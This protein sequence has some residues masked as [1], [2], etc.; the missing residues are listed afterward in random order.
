MAQ[1]RL[2]IISVHQSDEDMRPLS[3]FLSPQ[4]RK[5]EAEARFE[6]MWLLDPQRFH[7][8]RNCMQK[9]IFERV[10]SFLKESV[11]LQGAQ[12][13]DLGC[14]FGLLSDR[15]YEAGADIHAIDISS[16]ALQHLKK[17]PDGRWHPAQD[18]MPSTS[19]PNSQFDIVICK[20]LIADILPEDYRLFFSE[21]ARILKPDGYL[22]CSSPID[23]Y[24]EGG[25]DRLFNLA[26]TEFA[27]S[28]VQYSYFAL[29]LR[30]KHALQAPSTFSQT[31]KDPK[32]RQ[33]ELT[34]RKGLSRWWFWLNTSPLCVGNWMG[35]EFLTK[36]MLS[37]LNHSKFMLLTLEKAAHFFGDENQISYATFLAKKK[38]LTAPDAEL[39]IPVERPKKREV[40]E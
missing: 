4:A 36:P 20:D 7:P 11:S 40:W 34:T 8:M 24:S 19:L 29:Y 13:A 10:W 6:R 30:L 26:E 33:K 17:H 37:F 39:T 15:L 38:A 21:L 3:P 23:I 12:A 27:I 2:N 5:K 22:L 1:S 28:K 35:L 14:G 25:R 32:R 31:W 16:R 18:A 9:E